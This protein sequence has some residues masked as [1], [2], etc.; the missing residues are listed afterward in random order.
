MRPL[1]MKTPYSMR[2]SLKIECFAQSDDVL[3]YVKARRH[4]VPEYQITVLLTYVFKTLLFSGPLQV[5]LWPMV[6]APRYV[7]LLET[8]LR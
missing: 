4:V 2:K 5:S 6:Q 3:V 1:T 7:S 8:M